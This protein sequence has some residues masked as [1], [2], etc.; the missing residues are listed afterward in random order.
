MADVQLD[1]FG[2]HTPVSELGQKP[3]RETI[4]SWYRKRYGYD[5]N[6]KCG[7]CKNLY[8]SDYG[9]KHW[10]KCRLIG[11]SSAATDIRL[12]DVA[13]RRWEQREGGE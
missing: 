10:Y 12:K 11:G 1:L 2:G 13:C 7:D 8:R 9:N 6:H 5:E 4:K 3:G